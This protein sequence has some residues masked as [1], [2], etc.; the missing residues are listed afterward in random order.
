[1]NT[2]SIQIIEKAAPETFVITFDYTKLL[3]VG[4]HVLTATVT[5]ELFF[6][7]DASP[8]ALLDGAAQVAAGGQGVL[9]RVKD[10]V[11]GCLYRLQCVADTDA[12][13]SLVMYG[14]VELLT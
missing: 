9:I 2:I 1:M 14:L 6:G 4:Q 3:D 13:D 12:D 7:V 11:P 8:E 5:S 10:G